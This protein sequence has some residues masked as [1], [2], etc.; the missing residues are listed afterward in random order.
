MGH[1]RRLQIRFPLEVKRG[2]SVWMLRQVRMAAN[3]FR[4]PLVTWDDG[5]AHAEKP[6]Q[7]LDKATLDERC[8]GKARICGL[9]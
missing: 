3:A 2:P 4:E 6:A 7:L 1:R 5:M 9:S 8:E